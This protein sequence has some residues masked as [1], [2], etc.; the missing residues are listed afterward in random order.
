MRTLAV[1]AIF[2]CSLFGL[3]VTLSAEANSRVSIEPSFEAPSL[4]DE[5][6]LAKGKKDGGRDD[7]ESEED[8]AP[9]GEDRSALDLIDPV[10]LD[11]VIRLR[12]ATRR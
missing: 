6:A 3:G 12:M 7:E 5:G 1:L 4:L 9:S 11:Q 2:L 8:F 10:E